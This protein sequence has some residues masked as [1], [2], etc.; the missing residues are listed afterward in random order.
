[1]TLVRTCRS[2]APINRRMAISSRLTLRTPVKVLRKTR[3]KTTVAVR[4]IFMSMPMPN[5]STNSGA[6]AIFGRL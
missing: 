2:L 4:M 1:M 6:R 3:K 5:H